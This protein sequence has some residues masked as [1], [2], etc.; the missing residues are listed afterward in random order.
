MTGKQETLRVGLLGL[1]TVGCGVAALL[2][3][4]ASEIA[5]R[6][7]R[8]IE[9]HGVCARDRS[10]H[11]DIDML[12]Y[13]WH[14]DPASLAGE[15]DCLVEAT[16]Q[17]GEPVLSA[18]LDALGRGV[19][20][21]TAN[22]ALLAGHGRALAER[23]EAGGAALAFEAAVAGGIP[24]VKALA[25]GLA[26]NGIA[27]V[28][29]VLNGTCNYILS[30]MER[31]GAGYRE[32]LAEAQ[33]LGYA[34]ADPAMDVE[35]T[36]AAQK[37]ALLAALAFGAEVD[38]DGVT[39]EGVE[40]VQAIDIEQAREMGFR[41][42]LLGVAR[43][44]E[45]G[46][47]QRVQPCLVPADSVLGSLDGVT[48][49][50]MV[51]GSAAGRTIYI[52]AGAGAGPTASAIV[53]DLVDVARGYRRPAFG[54]PTAT[55]RQ[56]P[57]LP[58]E[59]LSASYYLRLTLEDRPGSLARVAGALGEAGVSIDRLRQPAHEGSAVPVLLVTHRVTR[60]RLNQAL[61]AIA[62]LDVCLETPVALRIEQL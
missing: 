23:A 57:R 58:R 4:R 7:G 9:V 54:V 17:P 16:G 22:K 39:V 36:D 59:E 55:L 27:S 15:I 13:P 56:A 8:A 50:V 5:A 28:Y 37:L 38:M 53:A 44:A 10:R 35:G 51:E 33:R 30:A 40:R 24:V 43:H 18:L 12:G 32:A 46:L 47:E 29:G 52:G 3:E 6:A 21:V 1:G 41:I 31:D 11:R 45:G 25:E 62:A 2:K 48:N 14:A 49:A 61:A 34:E 20:V 60:A 26:G 19:H 42:R